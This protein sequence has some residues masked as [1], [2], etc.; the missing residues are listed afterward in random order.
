MNCSE[1]A[2]SSS[3][4]FLKPRDLLVIGFRSLYLISAW[5]PAPSAGFLAGLGKRP[6][7]TRTA[8][9]E[10]PR[11]RGRAVASTRRRSRSCA[12]V[13]RSENRLRLL[14]A[15]IAD[16]DAGLD[17]P[18]DD[19]ADRLVHFRCHF[20][21]RRILR[22]L[23]DAISRSDSFSLRGRLPTWVVRMR[24]RLKI[25]EQ[26]PSCRRRGRLVHLSAANFPAVQRSG[27][28]TLDRRDG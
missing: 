26:T 4:I 27:R 23:P 12:A 22:L 9:R 17:L 25:I 8:T 28:N 20:L 5:P 15:V 13:R 10:I 19:M 3:E 1:N 14:L 16:V 18:F 21:R 2:P 24:S 7:Q 11:I 6:H